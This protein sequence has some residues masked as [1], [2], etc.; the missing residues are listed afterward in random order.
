MKTKNLLLTALAAVSLFAGVVGLAACKGE[1]PTPGPSPDAHTHDYGEWEVTVPTLTATGSAKKVCSGCEEGTDGH[2]VSVTLPVLTDSGYTKS[3]DT[4]TCEAGGEA[5]Y[6]YTVE[7]GAI[8]FEAETAAKGHA[9][10]EQAAVTPT[11]TSEGNK[12]YYTCDNCTKVFDENKAECAQ[13]AWVLGKTNHTLNETSRKEATCT[14]DGNEAYWQCSECHK[15]FKNAQAT[16]EFGENEWVIAKHHVY[17]AYAAKA[18]TCTAPGNKKYYTCENCDKYFDENKTECQEN[19]WVL[20]AT[21]HT[22]LWTAT[23]EPTATTQGSAKAECPA[24]GADNLKT[25]VLPTLTSADVSVGYYTYDAVPATCE[26]DGEGNYHTTEAVTKGGTLT[27]HVALPAI[28]HQWVCAEAPEAVADG[29]TVSATCAN[30]NCGETRAFPYIGTLA[31]TG[32]VTIEKTGQYYIKQTE[33]TDLIFSIPIAK[34]G[35]YRV[36]FTNLDSIGNKTRRPVVMAMYPTT[37]N[38]NSATKSNVAQA[39]AVVPFGV[40]G[41]ATILTGE[42]IKPTYNNTKVELCWFEAQVDETFVGGTITFSVAAESAMT[43]MPRPFLFNFT[44]KEGKTLQ[45]GDN[46]VVITETSEAVDEYL[47]KS[48]AGGWY[49]ISIDEATKSAAGVFVAYLNGTDVSVLDSTQGLSARFEV[50]ASSTNKLVFMA[51]NRGTYTVKLAKSEKPAPTLKVGVIYDGSTGF[52]DSSGRQFSMTVDES[53]EEGEYTLW[54][55]F[56]KNMSFTKTNDSPFTVSINGGEP[57]TI[58][59]NFNAN[60]FAVKITVKGGD[61]LTVQAAQGVTGSLRNVKLSK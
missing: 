37:I 42:T 31:Q 54:F 52:S 48:E 43:T 28:G 32:T 38:V 21:G 60:Q 8:T 40:R 5:F 24:C 33:K 15:Y 55:P 61:V 50:E 9:Y 44:M 46:S 39:K 34:A 18:A 49:E 57:V 30:E 6:Y 41:D 58:A 27:F 59:M 4:A 23:Q 53:V 10:H 20:E 14:E 7:G 22:Y 35:K 25:A 36:E 16:A 3:G 51:S 26:E 13:N 29:G 2:E 56:D 11:C 1:E 19:D 47:F 17:E 12:L 45:E